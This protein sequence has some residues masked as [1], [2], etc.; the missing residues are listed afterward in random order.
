MK[1]SEYQIMINGAS[2]MR[3][4]R[5]GRFTWTKEN[6]KTFK[7]LTAAQKAQERMTKVLNEDPD[8][9]MTCTLIFA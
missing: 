2:G 9:A 6:W 8:V 4:N 5:N 7:S 3:L 1:A